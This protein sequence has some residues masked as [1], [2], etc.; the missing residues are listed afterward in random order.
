MSENVK[1]CHE[2]GRVIAEDEC[3]V[4]FE[5]DIYCEDCA[6]EVLI[7]CER[8]EDYERADYAVEVMVSYSGRRQMWC[9]YC[10]E[11][12]ACVCDDCD[13][14]F[15][16]DIGIVLRN[17]E[18]IC[19]HCEDDYNYCDQCGN[20]VHYS[21][22]NTDAEMCNMCVDNAQ[23]PLL[24]NYHGNSKNKKIGGCSKRWRGIW[25]GVGVELEIDRENQDRASERAL[26]DRLVEIGGDALVYER[27]GSLRNGFEIVTQ[28]HTIDAFYKIDWRGILNACKEYD[29]SSHD[30]G[31]CGLHMHFS[32]E[33]FGDTVEKQRNSIAKLIYFYE[34]N[35]DDIIKIS[36]RKAS[37]VSRWANNYGA[38]TREECVAIANRD[39]YERY[40]AINLTNCHTVEIRIMRGTLNLESFLACVDFMI[41]ICKKSRT[42]KWKNIDDIS[43]WLKHIN[44][45]TKNY[46][47]ERDAFKEV[48]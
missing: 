32:R 25:R 34:H 29:Y 21:D 11:N 42:I 19:P 1:I 9:A 18:R 4:L 6:N 8:C 3:S 28:P 39:N 38:S 17:G 45:N 47:R 43:E 13:E 7:W 37:E 36:R 31:T 20:Y 26:I 44:E 35:F 27:D 48:I 10:A 22:F 23:H 15:S 30:I 5:N 24:R 33:I 46:I 16:D 41:S 2:C 40:H 14:Y 12:Y